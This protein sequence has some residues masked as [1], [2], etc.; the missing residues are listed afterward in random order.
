MVIIVFEARKD[1]EECYHE[2]GRSWLLLDSEEL[3]S[4]DVF[5]LRHRAPSINFLQILQYFR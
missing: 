3:A 5:V 2:K 1:K 4:D